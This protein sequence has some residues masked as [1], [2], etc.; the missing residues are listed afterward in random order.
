MDDLT[1]TFVSTAAAIGGALGTMVGFRRLQEKRLQEGREKVL[2]PGETVVERNQNR[3]FGVSTMHY[4]N[5]F[6]R[7]I[8]YLATYSMYGMVVYPWM[9]L[10]MLGGIVRR[11]SKLTNG[12]MSK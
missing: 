6:S 8:G 11:N 2:K 12:E 9:P 3:L 7:T 10:Y 1:F 5:D 4:A